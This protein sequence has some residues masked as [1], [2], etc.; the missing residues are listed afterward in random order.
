MF[1]LVTA[2]DS[3]DEPNPW[4]AGIPDGLW[5]LTR[6]QLEL[7][8]GTIFAGIYDDK[9]GFH[10]TVA[11]NLAK[12][13]TN[14]SIALSILLQGPHD[15]A[16]A[17]DWQFPEA[18]GSSPNYTRINK[19]SARLLAASQAQDPRLR[20]WYEWFGTRDGANIGWGIY[21]NKASSSDDSHDWHI[22]KS[23][24]TAYLLDW[25]TYHG[26]LSVL[27][28][29]TL[30]AFLVRGG[31]VIE[32]EG[33]VMSD[34]YDLLDSL[35]RPQGAATYTP[36]GADGARYG[37][38]PIA[39]GLEP[40]ARAAKDARIAADNTD[41]L[42]AELAELKAGLAEIKALLTAHAGKD[43]PVNITD[44]QV[45]ILAD[46]ISSSLLEVEADAD[47]ARAATLRAAAGS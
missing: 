23:V 26:M 12:W 37:S 42:K 16:R 9:P 22:H 45:V 39:A 19:Y 47:E 6:R 13:P 43:A 34:A 1:A 2:L 18:Q 32:G 4:P 31:Q 7:E 3:G 30:E 8:P 46:R 33:H 44:G 20:G 15:M 14:Y 29:E 5:W 36:P 10:N 28:G 11:H 27:M 24:I 40:A 38:L 25:R 41:V 35:K 17:D 21:K